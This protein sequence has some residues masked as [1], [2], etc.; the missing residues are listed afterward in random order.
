VELDTP[1][2]FFAA[3]QGKTDEVLSCVLADTLL[4][5]HKATERVTNTGSDT[6]TESSYRS[7]TFRLKKLEA[8]SPPLLPRAEMAARASSAPHSFLDAI[9]VVLQSGA[10]D[11]RT[12]RS[13]AVTCWI[14]REHVSE[15]LR[16]P[17]VTVDEADGSWDNAAFLAR[18]PGLQRLHVRGEP[19]V[20]I[21][22]IATLKSRPR[23]RLASADGTKQMGSAA[24]LFLGAFLAG[25]IHTIR[26]SDNLT[27]AH[28]DLRATGP[29]C[30]LP[31]SANAVDQSV[32][33]GALASHPA[34]QRL[35][36]T[37]EAFKNLVVAAKLTACAV[38]TS[39]DTLDAVSV[40]EERKL[41]LVDRAAANKVACKRTLERLEWE[42]EVERNHGI[43]PRSLQNINW[44]SQEVS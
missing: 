12:S 42:C 8:C 16:A 27:Y 9:N 1:A 38:A 39:A 6:G 13:T 11:L 40:E 34:I 41:L 21:L 31:L 44:V 28:L 3:H 18:L 20:P 22:D 15:L 29:T 36:G 10:L 30:H 37:A 33:V 14:A 4:G 19:F 32:V 43:H 2:D 23:L 5:P 26:L 35:S 17:V 25:G 7:K 24:A